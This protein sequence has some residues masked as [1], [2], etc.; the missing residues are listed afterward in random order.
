[1]RTFY[2]GCRSPSSGSLL[3][4]CIA[5]WRRYW[6]AEKASASAHSRRSYIGWCCACLTGVDSI[7]SCILMSSAASSSPLEDSYLSLSTASSSHSNLSLEFG[8]KYW[9]PHRHNA[10]AVTILGGSRCL[11]R[12]SVIVASQGRSSRSSGC[13]ISSLQRAFARP[14]SRAWTSS[15]FGQ[16]PFWATLYSSL[17]CNAFG[18]LTP[19]RSFWFPSSYRLDL[20]I[21]YSIA[22]LYCWRICRLHSC[23]RHGWSWTASSIQWN[24]ETFVESASWAWE[25]PSSVTFYC[26]L[27][28]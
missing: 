7:G 18:R 28:Y 3:A 26:Q 15:S 9:R 5:R 2:G 24:F 20:A 12:S 19:W 11:Y 22:C 1:M 17:R 16:S 27:K 23:R 21:P 10:P 8:S 4:S 13:A 6:A 25:P 14:D